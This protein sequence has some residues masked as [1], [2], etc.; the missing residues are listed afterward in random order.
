MVSR[1]V[2]DAFGA[3]EQTVSA[4][5]QDY[6]FTGREF[7]PETGLYYYRAR[8]YDAGQGRF[9]QSDPLGFAAGDLNLYAYTWN[10][11]ANWSDPSGLSAGAEAAGLGGEAL[12]LG[13]PAVAIVGQ[14]ASC[15]ANRIRTALSE[16]GN[17]LT[18]GSDV[19]Q[20]KIEN[21]VGCATSVLAPALL[22]RKFPLT[23]PGRSCG[24][25]RRASFVVG[26]EVQTPEGLVAIETLRE[27]DLVVARNEEDGVSGLFEV[28]GVMKRQATDVYWLSLKAPDGKVA[29]LGVTSEHPLFVVGRGWSEVREI[30]PDDLIRD[31]ALQ[32]L[33]V[34]A[35]ELDTTPQIVHNLEIAGAH[36]YFAGEL[37]AWGHNTKTN[38][39]GRVFASEAACDIAK[40]ARGNTSLKGGS[41]KRL[42]Q[43]HQKARP[44]AKSKARGKDTWKSRR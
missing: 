8:H 43:K 32:E 30:A 11:P 18:E 33:A 5:L 34:L 31:A 35:V 3:R 12:T 37:G 25:T 2:Y 14:G 7:D 15:V 27:G 41:K 16:I 42:G 6:G 24:G 20:A 40:N 13:N 38:K 22:L 4:V 17:R 29:R 44:G 9:I 10:D 26:T 1:Y 19:S 28:S 21:L 36:T 39:Q 23:P